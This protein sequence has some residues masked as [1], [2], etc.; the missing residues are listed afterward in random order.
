MLIF[1]RF[2]CLNDAERFAVAVK[3]TFNLGATVYDSQDR[4]NSVDPFPFELTPPIVLVERP[5]RPIPGVEQS[6]AIFRGEARSPELE[7]ESKVE[8]FVSQFGGV[9][10]GT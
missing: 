6:L 9:Y 4:S 1:N 5:E 7:L 2:Q 8:E 10:A 3:E